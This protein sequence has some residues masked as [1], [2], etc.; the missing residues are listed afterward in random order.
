MTFQN[1]ETQGADDIGNEIAHDEGTMTDND[2]DEGEDGEIIENDPFI[3]SLFGPKTVTPDDSA[4]NQL[5]LQSTKSEVQKGLQNDVREELLKKYEVK[6]TAVPFLQPPKVN[7]EVSLAVTKSAKTRDAY[8]SASQ[9]QVGASLNAFGLGISKFLKPETLRNFN[10]DIKEAIHEIAEGLHLLADHHYR[11]SL[12][13]R[14]FLKSGLNLVA[15]NAT[16]VSTVDDFLFGKDFAETL[17]TAQSCEKTS[18]EITKLAVP[19]AKKS[20]QPVRAPPPNRPTYNNNQPSTSGNAR[21]PARRQSTFSHQTGSHR[22]PYRPSNYHRSRRST[23][24]N[25][26]HRR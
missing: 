8:Q 15:K 19:T 23:S 1:T 20:Q 3:D 12:A 9:A 21:A 11:L 13:R 5:V 7:P 26:Y 10:D 18:R 17:K 2:G 22:Q 25:R 4:W 24:K 14:A 16:D 6:N